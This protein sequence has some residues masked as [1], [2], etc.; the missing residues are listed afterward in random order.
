MRIS[1]VALLLPWLLLAQDPEPRRWERWENAGTLEP[2]SRIT[3]KIRKPHRQALGKTIKGIYAASDEKSI[4]IELPDNQS[5]T[6]SKDAVGHLTVRTKGAPY[7]PW[8]GLGVG[9][10]IGVAVVSGSGDL[11]ASG[12]AVFGTILGG[13]PG[14]ATGYIVHRQ[15]R[16]K[17]VYR[18]PYLT[19]RK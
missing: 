15:L 19:R 9:A 11:T 18:P 14:L 12:Q 2:G 17:T 8:V 4:T 10:V 5:Q 1:L 7:A 13:L 16:T 6:I 3:L